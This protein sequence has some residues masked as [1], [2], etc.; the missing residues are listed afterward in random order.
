MS[1]S[2]YE[3]FFPSTRKLRKY[4]ILYVY[5][6][7]VSEMQFTTLFQSSLHEVIF[8]Q[9]IHFSPNPPCS[10]PKN[11]QK[12]RCL[13]AY[14]KI[15]LNI[16]VRNMG[17]RRKQCFL[18]GKNLTVVCLLSMRKHFHLSMG[19]IQIHVGNFKAQG[20]TVDTL[21]FPALSNFQLLNFTC[22]RV[23]PIIYIYL[24]GLLQKGKKILNINL[25]L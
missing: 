23:K 10:P 4:C 9:Y 2:S 8:V 14:I 7:E 15:L 20:R 12:A 17:K 18:D 21:L 25:Y 22:A 16:V 6:I 11:T 13:G 3:T 1:S 19:V 24:E 5:Y